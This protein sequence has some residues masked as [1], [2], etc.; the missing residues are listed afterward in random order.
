MRAVVNQGI[1]V[2]L[3]VAQ[4]SD[5]DEL[6]GLV[7]AYHAFEGISC[8]DGD[9]DAAVSPLLGDSDLGRCWLIRAGEA[10][11][12]YL[13]LCFGYSIE[14]GGRDGFIDEMYLAEPFRGQGVGT[15]AL[16][17]LKAEAS[18]LGVGAL[19]LEVARTNKRAQRLYEKAGFIAR[20]PFFLMSAR[21]D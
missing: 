5:L 9:I 6:R 14:F 17:L 8:P 13:A 18:A 4:I 11:A 19:H 16:R 21:L 1:E 20:A 7:R 2:S 12:G 3:Q 15:A 10:T